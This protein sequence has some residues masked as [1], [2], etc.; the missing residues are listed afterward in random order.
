MQR[1]G[2]WRLGSAS[3]AAYRCWTTVERRFCRMGGQSQFLR[4]DDTYMV[5]GRKLLIISAFAQSAFHDF[6]ENNEKAGPFGPAF[7]AE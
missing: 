1:L 7:P 6:H 5:N 4:P 2:R 3:I